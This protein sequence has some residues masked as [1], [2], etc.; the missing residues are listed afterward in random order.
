MAKGV[1][2]G[3]GYISVIPETSKFAAGIEKAAKDSAQKAAAPFKQAGR[4]SAQGFGK[5]FGSQLSQSLP[6]SGFRQSLK[7]YE[8]TSAKAGAAAG[9]A[10]GT[11]FTAAATAGVA[12]LGY[13]L[14]KGFERFQSL[15]AA[16]H[17]LKNLNRTF[18]QTGKAAID[19]DRVMKDVEASVTGTPFSLSEAFTQATNAMA[20]GVTDV[21]KYMTTVA[22]AAAFAGDDIGNIGQAFTQVINQG[23]VDAGILQNQLRNLPIRAWLNEVYGGTEDMTKAISEGRVGWE[24]LQYVIERFANGTA[25]TAGDTVAGSIKNMQ[26]A[27][28]KLGAEILSALFGGP[29]EDGI[30]GL[31]GAIDVITSK[32]KQLSS[33]VSAHRNEIKEFFDGAVGAVQTLVGAVEGIVGI[34][35]KV[36][37]GVDDV[38]VAFV[39][40]KSISGVSSLLTSLGLVKTTLQA[41]LP[42]AAKTGANG[43]SAALASV[44][45]PTWLT[46]LLG[47]DIANAIQPPP[48]GEE[49]GPGWAPGRGLT[50]P[51]RIWE[52]VTGQRDIHTGELNQPNGPSFTPSPALENMLLPGGGPARPNFMPPVPGNGMRWVDGQGWVKDGEELGLP[53]DLL[54]GSGGGGSG[55]GGSSTIPKPTVPFN[56]TLPPWAQGGTNDPAMFSAQSSWLEQR[57]ELEEKRAYL[58]ELEA[59]GVA[60]ASQIQDAKNAVLQ[61]ERDMH[62]QDLRLQQ[63]RAQ[64]YKKATDTGQKTAEQFETMATDLG[65]VVQLDE[66]LGI[67]RGLVG[68]A[69]NLLK[70]VGGLAAAPIK[71]LLAGITK[72][73][74]PYTVESQMEAM[75]TGSAGSAGGGF[76]GM[77]SD[78]F[79]GGGPG[80]AS[81][82]SGLPG[83]AP[84]GLKPGTNISYGDKGFP[85]WVYQMANAFGLQASTYGGHQES[86]RPDIGA[87]PNPLGLNRGIDWSGPPANLSRFSRFLQQTGLAEQLIYQ[88]PD[89]GEQFGF[90]FGVDYGGD[91]GGHTDHAH[92]RHGSAPPPQVMQYLPQLMPPWTQGYSNGGGV[93]TVP[94]ML[95]PGEHVLTTKDVTKMGGQSGVYSFRNALHRNTG[96]PIPQTP[97]WLDENDVGTDT[98]LTDPVAPTV[99]TPDL[100]PTPGPEAPPISQPAAPPPFGGG[101]QVAPPEPGPVS[102]ELA[103]QPVTST[104]PMLGPDG[105][106]VRGADGKI[107]GQDGRPIQGLASSAQDEALKR[108]A[109]FIPKAAQANTVAGTSNLSRLWMTGAEIVNGL[110][111]QGASAASTA[112]SAAITGA[113]FG[114]GAA[115]AAQAGSAASQFA[116][117]LGAQAAKRSVSY[118]YQMGGIASDALVEQLFPF[119]APSIIGFDSAQNSINSLIEQDKKSKRPGGVYDSG[120]MLEPGG[121]A[122]NMSKRPEPVLTQQQW[123]IMANTQPAQASHG[124]NI[125][126]ISVSDVDELSRSLS[127][128][129]RL[130]AM[131]YTGRPVS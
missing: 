7:Q 63:A 81:G 74:E 82:L 120:G 53:P 119:G 103:P 114:A 96:G 15:D 122:V 130:A 46:A 79:G 24:Q 25:K 66:D 76:G 31:K 70:F 113:S 92:T 2:L 28:A 36:G 40:W 3:V 34:L 88:N 99:P 100:A 11:A 10:L 94:A 83:G 4:T 62:E 9:K 93:D 1:E 80:A 33:W 19:V 73:L 16:T 117:G 121:V 104:P 52:M 12:G 124:I 64:S 69:E 5:S 128:R 26:T 51:K 91:F 17:R 97:A 39:A 32:L 85:Q 125:E 14:F 107:L 48:D 65:S 98:A 38:V 59:S 37:I 41:D 131:Q 112:V 42:A 126:N 58:N 50:A 47:N 44:A 115:G 27:F 23:K 67:S 29:T 111:D 101:T 95:T 60:E 116:I 127:A 106:P 57:H 77:F 55:G 86:S 87:A 118:W 72:E 18:Q 123:D 78:L 75:K 54:P 110:I 68:M 45:I 20:S 89:S 21:K 61:A 84:Y 109:G 71:G 22:D 8:T 43:I 13:T 30:N 49:R 105:Q 35:D 108:L 102:A 56:Q 129:Q 6:M 90:P